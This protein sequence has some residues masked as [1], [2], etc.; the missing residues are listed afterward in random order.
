VD[1]FWMTMSW[2]NA[3]KEI[4]SGQTSAKASPW[5][6]SRLT[7]T[8]S[9]DDLTLED[10]HFSGSISMPKVQVPLIAFAEQIIREGAK[11]SA[12]VD[13]IKREIKTRREAG[14]SDE[15]EGKLKEIENNLPAEIESEIQSLAT[16]LKISRI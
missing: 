16:R 6:E 12:L 2:L 4:L 7:L 3:L 1:E 14:V 10:V 8:R 11:F 9:G 13:A 5:E 15:I